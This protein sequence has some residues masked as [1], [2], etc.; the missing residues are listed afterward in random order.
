MSVPVIYDHFW[1][2]GKEEE[3][4]ILKE[5]LSQ[6]EN[7]HVSEDQPMNTSKPVGINAR[8]NAKHDLEK[9][10]AAQSLY[11]YSHFWKHG[12]QGLASTLELSPRYPNIEFHHI[13]ENDEHFRSGCYV[14]TQNGVS[15]QVEKRL[16][17]MS[18]FQLEM[19]LFDKAR[20]IVDLEELDFLPEPREEISGAPQE[21]MEKRLI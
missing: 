13:R 16:A 11:Y 12:R 2:Y 14:I 3:L 17:G 1:C 19:E 6:I 9:Q 8:S 20:D 15:V 21:S 10:N 4:K 5:E 18:Y 7:L